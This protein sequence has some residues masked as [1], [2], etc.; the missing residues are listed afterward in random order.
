MSLTSDVTKIESS[1]AISITLAAGTF[2]GQRKTL[3]MTADGGD[4]TMTTAG[5]NLLASDVATSIVW[6]DVG[7]IVE[8][9]Y[10]GVKWAV[11]LN[12]G[13]TIS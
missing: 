2:P 1:A 4:V 7:D 11:A 5:G 8:L 9:V 13:A 10:T 3:V 6:N 12:K